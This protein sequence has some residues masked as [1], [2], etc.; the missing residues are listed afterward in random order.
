[1]QLSH[2][3]AADSRALALE[4]DVDTVKLGLSAV[5]VVVHVAENF[6]VV[7][8]HQKLRVVVFR[9]AADAL[10][11]RLDEAITFCS[12][13]TAANVGPTTSLCTAGNPTLPMAAIAG[14][15]VTVADRTTSCGD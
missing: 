3:G 11:Q 14:A 15:S 13:T 7:P 4:V 5:A 12:T 8:C 1:M 6:P 10:G 2:Q 9:A